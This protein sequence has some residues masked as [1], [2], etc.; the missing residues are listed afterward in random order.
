MYTITTYITITIYKK[1]KINQSHPPPDSIILKHAHP[2]ASATP[3]PSL[4]RAV[5][6]EGEEK[7]KG[8]EKGEKEGRV[9]CVDVLRSSFTFVT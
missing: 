5:K 4:L 6:K 1:S 8:E 2:P 7:K 3:S 9:L